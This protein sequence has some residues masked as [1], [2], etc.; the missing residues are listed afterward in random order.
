MK[1]PACARTLE[2]V[3][4]RN[5]TLDICKSGC[6]GIWFDR[7]E[8][9]HFDSGSESGGTDVLKGLHPQI[10][11]VISPE[12]RPCPKCVKYRMQRRYSC[13]KKNV[14]IDSCPGCS[15]IWLDTGELARIQDS[16]QTDD[17]RNQAFETL[18]T[19]DLLPRFEEERQ[20]IRESSTILQ[21]EKIFRFLR[22][23]YY[24]GKK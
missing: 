13:V 16:W 12:P 2:S 5:V 22:P 6:A 17:E 20:N 23:S 11:S 15:G 7:T 1:C 9:D 8:L 10:A 24:L 18:F 3:Q 21:L 19:N 4:V 14:E